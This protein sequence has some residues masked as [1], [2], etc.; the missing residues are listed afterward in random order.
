MPL[1][2]PIAAKAARVLTIPSSPPTICHHASAVASAIAEEYHIGRDAMDMI[3]MSPDPYHDSFDELLDLR[4]FDHTRHPTAGLSFF[5]QDGRVILAHMQPGTPGAKIPCWRTHIHGAWL[6]KIGT[7]I[8]H[9]I[10]DVQAAFSAT[11]ALGST[12][13]SLLFAHPEFRPDISRRG[14]LIVSTPH[15]SCSKSMT[16]STTDGSSLQCPF[17]FAGLFPTRLWMMGGF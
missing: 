17:T 10:L 12:H 8:I 7:H 4:Q 14:L 2:R 13:I 16:N 5:E 15:S 3:Y 1:P 6:L 11:Q 9:S